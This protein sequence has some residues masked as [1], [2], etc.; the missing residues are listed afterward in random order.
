LARDG[1][2]FA[3]KNGVAGWRAKHDE[4]GD[5]VERAFFGLDGAPVL[6]RDGYAGWRSRHD[7]RGNSIELAF[8]GVDG[9][10]KPTTRGGF[11]IRKGKVDD[12]GNETEVVY[13]DATGARVAS[14]AGGNVISRWHREYDE[15]D[16]VVREAFFD[17]RDRPVDDERGLHS[18]T[19]AL[20]RY[21]NVQ[22]TVCADASGNEVTLNCDDSNRQ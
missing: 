2:N 14:I 10:P 15:F 8:F 17:A 16:R 1:S 20:D 19:Y 9:T 5:E 7:E 4:R 21:G 12:R 18:L 13:H 6:H 22:N 3:G 11:A